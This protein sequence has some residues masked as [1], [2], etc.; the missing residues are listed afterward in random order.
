MRQGGRVT[1]SVE[2]S[3]ARLAEEVLVAYLITFA[4]F[5][6]LVLSVASP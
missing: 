5:V 1:A 6:A 4:L 2:R 3:F